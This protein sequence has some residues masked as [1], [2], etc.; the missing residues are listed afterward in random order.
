MR[1]L[2]TVL[3]A[4]IVS[5]PG[6]A[7]YTLAV[8]GDSL[9]AGHHLPQKDSFYAQLEQA[10]R[11]KGYPVTVLNASKSGETASGGVRKVNGLLALNPD[12]VI[13]E[14]GIND[15][16]SNSP[17]PA[18]RKNLASLITTF[19]NRQIPVLLV[20]MKT[21]PNKPLA[22]QQQLEEM[23]QSLATEYQLLLYPF[24]MEGIFN[25]DSFGDVLH[26]NDNLLPHD[27]HP[28]AKGVSVMVRGILPT[29]ERFLNQQG[30]RPQ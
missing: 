21:F 13:L 12:G 20:G 29:V 9:S 30:I 5:V 19:Q 27:I 28:S 24:F 11:S 23:Y 25:L 17:I 26:Q 1:F 10:L 3:L 8:F 16:F 4:L 18:I 15:S 6:M 14:L 22:Y 2:L 7:D